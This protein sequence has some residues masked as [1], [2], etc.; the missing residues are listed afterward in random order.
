M[1]ATSRAALQ[2]TF[3]APD[4]V[5]AILGGTQPVALTPERLKKGPELR[6]SGRSLPDVLDRRDGQAADPRPSP[7]PSRCAVQ[8][9]AAGGAS[10]AAGTTS[11][12]ARRVDRRLAGRAR[13]GPARALDP[14]LHEPLLPE[15]VELEDRPR[16]IARRWS[17]WVAAGDLAGDAS[18]AAALSARARVR[19]QPGGRFP[20]TP[21]DVMAGPSA[22]RRAGPC[23][24]I[25]R[26]SGGM[27][28]WI[29]TDG[30]RGGLIPSTSTADVVVGLA[31]EPAR[32][33]LSTPAAHDAHDC[34]VGR[35]GFEPPSK[36]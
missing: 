11:A 36:T 20:R 12:T 7:A 35:A 24:A 31:Q 23:C 27:N 19:K 26:I 34:P 15:R 28:H 30:T 1:S 9:R 33:Y 22:Q 25:S 5:E 29:C 16:A 4:L 10:V 18:L 6:C 14:G 21:R 32:H 3:L 8:P 17:A 2:C 13:L